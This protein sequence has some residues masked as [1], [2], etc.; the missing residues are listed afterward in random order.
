LYAA[1]DPVTPRTIDFFAEEMRTTFRAL[2][3]SRFALRFLSM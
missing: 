3:L 2:V 1:I